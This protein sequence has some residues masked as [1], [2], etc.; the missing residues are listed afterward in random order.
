MNTRP[1]YKS[2]LNVVICDTA[3]ALIPPILLLT[4]DPTISWARLLV[5]FRFSWIYSNCI[6]GVAFYVVPKVWMRT[7]AQPQWLRWSARIAAMFGACVVGS[8]AA[9]LLFI[10]FA[11][12]SWNEYM[13]QF[14]GSLKLAALLTI[15]AGVAIGIYSTLRGRL[16]EPTLRS[17]P[18]NWSENAR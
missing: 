7:C 16:E 18:R 10:G 13:P 4:L 8:L 2:I 17:A 6:G 9:G 14:Q 1:I 15:S 11:W 5:D 3:F 12:Q